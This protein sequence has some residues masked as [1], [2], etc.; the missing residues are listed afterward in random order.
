[1]GITIRTRGFRGPWRYGYPGWYGYYDPYWYDPYWWWDSSSDDQ[2]NNQDAQ[3][4][5]YAQADNGPGYDDQQNNDQQSL[6]EQSARE[7]R[8]QDLYER[9]QPREPLH[10]EL[11]APSPPTTLIFRDQHKQE[12]QNYAIVGHTLWSFSTQRTEKIPLA[13]L[14]IPATQKANED[15]GVNFRV[16]GA[17]EGQ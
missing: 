17:G 1:V 5:D 13:D 10:S 16:P 2:N 14:D 4:Q 3:Y 12:I 11:T 9:S 8:E 7:R 6:E 15:R